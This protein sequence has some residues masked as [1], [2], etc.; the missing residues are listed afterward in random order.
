MIG[1]TLRIAE[2]Y[3]DSGVQRSLRLLHFLHSL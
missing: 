3:F 2:I 1:G